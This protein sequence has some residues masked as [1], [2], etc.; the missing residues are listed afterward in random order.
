MLG[1]YLNELKDTVSF[2]KKDEFL[3]KVAAF[4]VIR[5]EA[6]HKMRKSNLD[7]IS[8][9]LRYM[10]VLFDNIFE[11]YDEIQ[12]DFRITFHSFRKDV[13]FDEYGPENE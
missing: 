9:R 8:G 12:D 13:F 10:K 4:N 7:E 2:Y 3:E 11:L 5:N 6:I 1:A